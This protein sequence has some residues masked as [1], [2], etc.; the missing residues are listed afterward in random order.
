LKSQSRNKIVFYKDN[1]FDFSA[2]DI[3]KLLAQAIYNLKEESKLPMKVSRELDL[4]LNE[5]IIEHKSYGRILVISNIGILLEPD[6]KQ[7]FNRILENYSNNNT[8]FVH[9]NGD[10]DEEYLYF[11]TKEQGKKYNIK[12]LSHITL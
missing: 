12:N 9:W 2:I 5:A 6:L 8:L 4:I 1:I 3:G 7:D 10:I 11:L